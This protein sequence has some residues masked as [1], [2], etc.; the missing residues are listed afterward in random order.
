METRPTNTLC[1]GKGCATPRQQWVTQS[2][3]GPGW[4]GWAWQTRRERLRTW[5]Y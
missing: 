2:G 4:T 1:A 5:G 3:P